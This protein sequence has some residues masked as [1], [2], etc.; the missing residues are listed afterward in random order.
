MENKIE[1]DLK[2][3]RKKAKVDQVNC[4]AA[5][6]YFTKMIKEIPDGWTATFIPDESGRLLLINHSLSDKKDPKPL[7]TFKETCDKISALGLDLEKG[8]YEVCG[9]VIALEASTKPFEFE[10]GKF[11]IHIR[12]CQTD[13]CDFEVKEETVKVAKPVG[14][15]AEALT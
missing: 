7:L 9:R 8:I 15:C 2:K 6:S 3:I 12:Q 10:G 1:N 4:I 11:H 13:T 14:F 5:G